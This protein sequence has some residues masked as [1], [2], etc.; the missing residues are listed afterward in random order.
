MASWLISCSPP[1]LPIILLEVP[2]RDLEDAE[3]EAGPVR[4]FEAAEDG[5]PLAAAEEERQEAADDDDAEAVQVCH[6][7]PKGTF[8]EHGGSRKW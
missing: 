1:F 5:D 4:V 3:E 6:L 7:P 8:G 2:R